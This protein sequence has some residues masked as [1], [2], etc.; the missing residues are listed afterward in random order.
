MDD[1]E[2]SISCDGDAMICD[3]EGA[4]EAGRLGGPSRNQST[5]PAARD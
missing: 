3:S 1:N 5:K 2:D 4:D